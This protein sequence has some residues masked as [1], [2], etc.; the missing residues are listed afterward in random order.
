MCRQQ[1]IKRAALAF[2]FMLISLS[3]GFAALNTNPVD[4]VEAQHMADKILDSSLLIGIFDCPG[5]NPVR[6]L[7][8]GLVPEDQDKYVQTM[9]KN[10]LIKLNTVPGSPDNF[11]SVIFVPMPS[12]NMASDAPLQFIPYP[13]TRWILF[14]KTG[15]DINGKPDDYWTRQLQLKNAEQYLNSGT[16]YA[17][18]DEYHG[19]ACLAWNNNYEY[20]S[21]VPIASENLIND[22]I[23]IRRTLKNLPRGNDVAQ[24]GERLTLL[25]KMIERMKDPYGKAVAEFVKQKKM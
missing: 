5:N 20:Q 17:L 24:K 18:A 2:T 9:M 4:S 7:K 11:D 22:F 8:N 3:Q 12:V 15:F 13:E 21:Q 6:H 1:I 19:N 25:N 14:L 16:L 23:D 10:G